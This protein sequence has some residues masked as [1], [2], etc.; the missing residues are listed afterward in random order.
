MKLRL[1]VV[2]IGLSL[3]AACLVGAVMAKS[4][5][6]KVVRPT[7]HTD[8]VSKPISSTAK[9]TTPPGMRPVV[10]AK[11]K[12]VNYT[13]IKPVYE[14]HQKEVSYTVMKPK[15]ETREKTVTYTVCTMVPEVETKTVNYTTCRMERETRQKLVEYNELRY[16]PIDVQA[17]SD[18]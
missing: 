8:A 16:E 9:P 5:A 13:V 11:S 10:E 3:G 14:T 12:L 6:T 1:T 15:Y 17:S 4:A 7:T 18:N 2:T